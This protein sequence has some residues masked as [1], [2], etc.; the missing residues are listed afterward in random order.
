MSELP[1]RLATSLARIKRC[2][3]VVL[4]H[5]TTEGAT[6]YHLPM[7]GGRRAG[8][9]HPASCGRS[10]RERQRWSF[11]WG[12]TD[13]PFGG[14]MSNFEDNI[15]SRLAEIDREIRTAKTGER[16][17]LQKERADLEAK[18]EKAAG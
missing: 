4:V 16:R 3:G 18:L 1:K 2:G 8:C 13:L 7:G 5:H 14:R 6:N 11:R 10:S 12:R 9:H 15:R 17:T